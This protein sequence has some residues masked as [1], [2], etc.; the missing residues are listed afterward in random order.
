MQV[1]IPPRPVEQH[2]RVVESST[3]LSFIEQLHDKGNF[4][5]HLTGC[6]AIVQS[7]GWHTTM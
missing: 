2:V 5:M 7:C 4:P 3:A 1:S 6:T